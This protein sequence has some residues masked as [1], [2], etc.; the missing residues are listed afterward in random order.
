MLNQTPLPR[1]RFDR[2]ATNGPSLLFAYG[3]YLV[4]A[5]ITVS[6]GGRVPQPLAWFA[7]ACVVYAT[8]RSISP[9][10]SIYNGLAAALFFSSFASKPFG[11]VHVHHL[12][13]WLA[14]IALI[15]SSFIVSTRH[16]VE[17]IPSIDPKTLPGEAGKKEE[18]WGI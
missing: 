17:A 18:R 2:A 14:V 8:S 1:T 11:D 5:A 3:M 4:I 7:I 12:S 9:G 16:H 10:W 13:G 6:S 15:T